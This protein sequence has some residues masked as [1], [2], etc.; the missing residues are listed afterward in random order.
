MIC[1]FSDGGP[2]NS[3]GPQ[4]PAQTCPYCQRTYLREASLREHVKF[5]L[6]RD[7]GDSVCPLCGF[8]TPFRAQMERHLT[9][10]SQTHEKVR[11]TR[12]T[13]DTHADSPH[14][15][16]APC[17]SQNSL[18]EPSMENRKFKCNQCGKA[19][20]YK[21]HLKEHLRIHSGKKLHRRNKSVQDSPSLTLCQ[22]NLFQDI[23]FRQLK[24]IYMLNSYCCKEEK[25]FL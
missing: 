7:G 22:K 11:H 5:C 20:K 13:D 3:D 14:V 23:I 19:F 17:M 6:D 18:S 12:R 16:T 15:L 24:H 1:V 10:H 21:H 8:S 4:M 9:L 25:I 2:L